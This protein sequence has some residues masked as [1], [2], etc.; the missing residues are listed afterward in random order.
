MTPLE[1]AARA[2]FRADYPDHVDANFDIDESG[3]VMWE[4]RRLW[5]RDAARAVLTAIREP[6]EG[7]VGEGAYQ[8]PCGQGVDEGPPNARDAKDCWQAMIDA[9]L[10]ETPPT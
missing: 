10:S 7:M 8:I 1:R 4:K 6:S 5:Y 3:M 9:A 2:I